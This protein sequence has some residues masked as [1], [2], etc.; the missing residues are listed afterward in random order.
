[1][2]DARVTCL[3]APGGYGKTSLAEELAERTD[4]RLLRF[5]MPPASAGDDRVIAIVLRELAAHGVAVDDPSAIADVDQLARSVADAL[6][7]RPPS[8][9]LLDDCHAAID[10]AALLLDA[11]TADPSPHRIVAAGRRTPPCRAVDVLTL[12]PDDLAP[13]LLP[14]SD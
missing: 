11:L 13:F 2:A 1:M 4:G 9:V 12:G 14:L 3:V 10:A 5:V 8:V 6:A 7:D